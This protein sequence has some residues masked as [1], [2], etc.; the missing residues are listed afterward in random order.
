MSLKEICLVALTLS[1]VFGTHAYVVPLAQERIKL[2]PHLNEDDV[3]KTGR[4]YEEAVTRGTLV[5]GFLSYLQ[6]GA[7]DKFPMVYVWTGYQI[8]LLA[9]LGL[10]TYSL[11]DTRK[12]EEQLKNEKKD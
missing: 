1:G 3:Y 6:M 8:I 5:F 12:K 2:F 9:G 4:N 7:V 10:Y 11:N